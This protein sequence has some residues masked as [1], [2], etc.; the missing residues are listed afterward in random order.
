MLDKSFV[1]LI[2]E[3]DVRLFVCYRKVTDPLWDQILMLMSW[4][5]VNFKSK[6]H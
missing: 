1:G 4:I 6:N 5:S 2:A 3:G